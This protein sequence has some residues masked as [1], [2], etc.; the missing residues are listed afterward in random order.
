MSKN[1][2]LEDLDCSKNQLTKL[3][4]IKNT[5]NAK[6]YRPQYTDSKHTTTT[7][8]LVITIKK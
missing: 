6:C 4:S 3:F 7:D 1:T 8:N 5:W 2:A